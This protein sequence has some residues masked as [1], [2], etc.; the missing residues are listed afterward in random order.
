MPLSRAAQVAESIGQQVI[1]SESLKEFAASLAGNQRISIPVKA[2]LLSVDVPGQIVAPHRLPGID[3]A[4]KQR[5]FI[6]DLLAPGRTTSPTIYWIQQTGFTNNA[7][8]VAE[9]TQNLTAIFSSVKKSRQFAL[10]PTCSKPQS[11]SWTI[12]PSC[13][14]QLIPK[15]VSA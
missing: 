7:R 15:C 3:V 13:S 9:G 4:P 12:L 14:Q 1:S 6:R 5:L 10:S 2:A 11:R 8:V